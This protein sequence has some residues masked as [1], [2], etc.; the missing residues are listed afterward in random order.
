MSSQ[1]LQGSRA[2]RVVPSDT[3]GIPDIATEAISASTATATTANKL[4]DSTQTFT[5]TAVVGGIIY[6]TTD[7]TI[8]TVSSIDS[9]TTLSISADIMANTEA[10]RM[11]SSA[12]K[13]CVLYVGVAG[14][15]SVNM[16]ED[17]TDTA[18]I[19]TAAPAGY[20]PIHVDRVNATGTAAT[21]ILAI[22]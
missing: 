18:V 16:T 3:I 11:F 20:H 19:F 14:N 15:L 7:G 8:A 2:L 10:Y 13:D 12:T 4:V 1:K 21:D 17:A 22:W 5:E 6:N 9:D